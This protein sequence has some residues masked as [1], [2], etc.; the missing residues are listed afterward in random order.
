M[1]CVLLSPA[2]REAVKCGFIQ[3]GT[4]RNEAWDASSRG[5]QVPPWHWVYEIVVGKRASRLSTFAVCAWF[6]GHVYEIVVGKR[7]SGQ[8]RGRFIAPIA[9]LSAS[10]ASLFHFRHPLLFG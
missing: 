8:C 7:A 2:T 1:H 5:F 6:A 10:T 9:D 3:H 4:W